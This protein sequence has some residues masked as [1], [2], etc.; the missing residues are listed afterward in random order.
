MDLESPAACWRSRASAT[1]ISPRSPNHNAVV[2]HFH[3]T[4]LNEC[5]R[6]AFHRRSFHSNK[7]LQAET[8]AWLAA[9]NF[10]RSNRG[11]YARGRIPGGMMDPRRKVA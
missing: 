4:I 9:Y 8:D 7:Q 1:R 2:E 3:Q 10:C 11:D 5:W 6:P